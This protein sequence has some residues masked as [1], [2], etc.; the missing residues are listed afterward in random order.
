MELVDNDYMMK[1]CV[2]VSMLCIK[3]AG[4]AIDHT[5]VCGDTDGHC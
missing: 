3:S 2:S 4:P 1:H 5:A